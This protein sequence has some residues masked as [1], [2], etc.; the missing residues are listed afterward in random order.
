M[1][2]SHPAAISVINPVGVTIPATWLSSLG[3]GG[4]VLGPLSVAATGVAVGVAIV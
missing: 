1:C 3:G 4:G 2:P